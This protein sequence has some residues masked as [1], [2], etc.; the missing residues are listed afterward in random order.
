MSFNSYD[1]I[2]N[3]KGASFF[4]YHDTPD[5]VYKS[6]K[7]QGNYLCLPSY[8]YQNNTHYN[9]ESIDVLPKNSYSSTLTINGD[10]IDFDLPNMPM[11]YYKIYLS[12]TIKNEHDTNNLLTIPS[13]LFLEKISLLKN[14]NTIVE[15]DDYFQYF[16]CL[17]R[18]LLNN[19]SQNF[20][21]CYGVSS[22]DFQTV[23]PI[24]PNASRSYLIDLHTWL[25][26][27]NILS[28]LIKDIILRVK[29]RKTITNNNNVLDSDI[30][31]S[32]VKLIFKMIETTELTIKHIYS[33][34]KINHLLLKPYH[35]T[36]LVPNLTNGVETYVEL[37]L[38]HVINQLWIFIT[39]MNPSNSQFLSFHELKDLYI[40]NQANLNILNSKKLSSLELKKEVFD[41]FNEEN[42]YYFYRKLD[43]F[44]VLDFGNNSDTSDKNYHS[45]GH[46]FKSGIH[47]IYFTPTATNSNLVFHIF[48]FIPSLIE[49]KNG[50]YNEI[51]N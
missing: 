28:S 6:M 39:N 51:F 16:K 19:N 43:K 50:E 14:G 2:K 34:P 42:K 48:A 29:F 46:S 41:V 8:A 20:E 24:G 11:L 33:H 32:D 35:Y 26:K 22:T 15:T 45:G 38:R 1:T 17:D 25:R 18:F 23:L 27:S 47:R 37:D 44:Y 10:K 36:R 30:I 3:D 13:P 31:F 7:N 4:N 12:F 9:M 49:I 21:D 5:I 40:T